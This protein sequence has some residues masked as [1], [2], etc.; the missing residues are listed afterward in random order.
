[1]ANVKI[2]FISAGYENMHTSERKSKVE[3]KKKDLQVLDCIGAYPRRYI[4]V[5]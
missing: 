2:H 5:V 1:M 3:I 4:T